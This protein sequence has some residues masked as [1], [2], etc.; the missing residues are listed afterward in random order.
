MFRSRLIAIQGKHL[1]KKCKQ[2]CSYG[3]FSFNLTEKY[4][5]SYNLVVAKLHSWQ[6]QFEQH[7]ACIKNTPPGYF[8]N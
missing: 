8:L 2:L 6:R 1:H 4:V 7:L 5:Y 3:A